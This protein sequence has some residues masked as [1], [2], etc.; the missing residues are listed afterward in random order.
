[1]DGRIERE[2]QIMSKVISLQEA[3]AWIHDGD[4]LGLGGNVLHR[5]PMAM[6]RELVRQNK[7]NLKLVKTAGAMDVDMLCFGGCVSSVDAGF[8]SYESEY[9]LAGHYRRAVEGGI[10]K[11]N[12][13]ACYTVI[14]ALRAASF[15]VGFM[16]VKGLIISDLI[17][18]ND[19]FMR[20]EDP[21]TREPVTAVKA[22]R[23][24][25]A[26]IHVQEADEEGNARITG[27]LFEDVLFSRAARRV[28][29]T[30]EHIV[31][32][33]AFTGSQQK[34]DIPHFLVDGVVR[35]SKGAAPCSCSGSYDIDEKNLKRFKELKNLDGLREYLKE[36]EK[37]DYK[38]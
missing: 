21:F 11:G 16:P 9:S 19:Y 14:S 25:V 37:S 36:F 27:P 20:V 29:L 17:D 26:V 22:I 35:V 23:P 6:V 13:H 30:T 4:I 28:I 10:V 34:A 32:S 12:E 33:S 24:D 3:A 7:R 5:A 18:A 2:D 15:G 31:R 38:G 1:M 8:I